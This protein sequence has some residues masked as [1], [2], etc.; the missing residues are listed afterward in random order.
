[1]IIKNWYIPK[2]LHFVKKHNFKFRLFVWTS[3]TPSSFV[4]TG[5]A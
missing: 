1:M 2:Q 5:E 4:G 3:H